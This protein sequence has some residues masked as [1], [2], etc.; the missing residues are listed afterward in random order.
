MSLK[1][2][3]PFKR[4]PKRITGDGDNGEMHICTVNISR[5][6][7]KL[8]EAYIM[9]GFGPSRSEFIRRA[10]DFYLSDLYK[11]ERQEE[12]DLLSLEEYYN[13]K[14]IRRMD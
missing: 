9:K 12:N 11:R 8:I 7:L 13:S 5:R 3:E 14:V 2:K 4:D 10:I 6:N 1:E